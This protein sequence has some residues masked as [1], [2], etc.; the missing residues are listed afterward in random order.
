V[1]T[2][3][4]S[5]RRETSAGEARALFNDLV[6]LLG[7]NSV[8]M[9]V[10]SI[11]LG[12][13][14]RTVLQE[15]LA[16]C[17]VMLVLIGRGWADAK[18]EEG[19]TRL[20][21]PSDFVRLEIETALKRDIVVTPVLVQGAHLPTAEQLPAEI[22][23]LAYRNAFELSHNRWES[24]VRE[25]IRRLHLE[26]R[27]SGPVS[28]PR[29]KV[30]RVWIL[31]SALIIVAWGGGLMVSRYWLPIG[32]QPPTGDSKRFQVVL[33]IGKSDPGSEI[34]RKVKSALLEAGYNVVSSD[35]KNDD[36]GSGVD[37]FSDDDCR[38]AA[39]IANIVS[40]EL[41]RNEP[42]LI[43]RRQKGA[44]SVG[45]VGVWISQ[46]PPDPSAAASCKG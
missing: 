34:E 26:K 14:F 12:R 33:H 35:H 39:D 1:S 28:P 30:L 40:K 10:D 25:M 37:F 15:I 24:D 36:Y 17:D 5:Y 20:G 32:L 18:D 19:K 11:A 9:D 29:N 6:A 41:P 4:I 22:S 46:K 38:G 8:F 16:S 21:N 23:N 44:T 3:F 45:R 42:P 27:R 31:V 43:I 7:Q 2:V 13:D